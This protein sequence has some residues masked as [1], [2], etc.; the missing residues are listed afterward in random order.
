VTT[1]RAIL[2][3]VL[4]LAAGQALAAGLIPDPSISDTKAW[5]LPAGEEWAIADDDGHS[6]ASSLRYSSSKQANVPAVETSVQ[7]AANSEYVLTAWLKSDGTLR[8]AVYVLAPELEDQVVGQIIAGGEAGQWLAASAR[9]NSGAATNLRVRIVADPRQHKGEAIPAGTAAIDDLQ[10]WPAAE[11]PADLA[12]PGG[13]MRQAPGENLALDM[14]YTISPAPNYGYSTDEGDAY[15]L[16]DG[17]YSVGYFWVQKTTVGWSSAGLIDITVDLEER[18]PICG[19]SYNTAAGVAGVGWPAA[20]FLMVSDDGKTWFD[21]GEL[22]TLSTVNG[23]PP[24]EGYAVHRFWTGALKTSGRY[25]KLLVGPGT[26]YSFCDEVEIYEGPAALLQV[27]RGEPLGDTRQAAQAK[28]VATAV[29]QTILTEAKRVQ[30]D[31]ANT[32]LP[33]AERERLE[34]LI[35]QAAQGA[36]DLPA[37]DGNYRAIVPLNAAHA[38]VLQ[39]RAALNR[40]SGAA[41]FSIWQTDPY[42]P[43]Q[44]SEVPPPDADAASLDVAMLRN[45]VRPA[46]LN[47]T[48]MSDAPLKVHLA[49]QDV[50]DAPCPAWAD[51]RVVAW[52]GLRGGSITGSALPEADK[53]H[54]GWSVS[55]P[56]GTTTQLW[57]NVDSRR[58]K[59][60]Q[61]SGSLAVKPEGLQ[62]TKVPLRVEVV[63]VQMPDKL[64]LALGGWDYTSGAYSGVT[65]ENLAS[66]VSFLQEYHIDSPWATS[67]VMPFGTHAADGTMTTPPSTAAM[68]TWLARWPKSRYYCVFNAFSSPVP[69]TD[70]GRKR[71]EDWITFWVDYLKTKGVAPYQLA[72]LLAD[73]PHNAEQDALIVSYAKIIREVQPEVNVFNDPTWHDPR[74]ITPDLLETSGILCPNRPMWLNSPEIFSEVFLAQQK[75]GRQLAFYSCS[76]P[77]RDLDPYSYHRLQAWDCFRLGMV[78]EFFWAFSDSG[79]GSA[80]NEYGAGGVCYSPQFLGP[81]GCTTSKHME[82][83]REGL[84]DHEYLVLATTALAEAEAAGTKPDAVQR[85]KE[86]LATAP[87]RVL[88]AEGVSSISWKQDKD[89]TEAD[90]VRLEIINLLK[91]LK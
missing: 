51:M 57:L 81:D 47:L 4:A 65:N 87:G 25:V 20:V 23:A 72:L 89:R 10:I 91:E 54:D 59:A 22:T 71:V 40:A 63:D 27:D 33:G 38:G 1:H 37:L 60:G 15:Q 84:Y 18:R 39:V 12:V 6:G 11:A 31:L 73:E 74:Q 50:V 49:L 90:V 5:T 9:L 68:D 17:V 70:A 64:S 69:D 55:I 8:P 85:G 34:Q 28:V 41:P 82:A 32:T 61:F 13:I 14:P 79:N 53:L 46:T 7:C 36:D 78:G 80:W 52:T 75:A 56:S 86:L 83:V 35:A 66:V 48:N 44:I 88:N 19:V 30:A 3:L 77:V 67:G 21:A 43:L 62:I 24:A 42:Y 58:M 29:S 45:E 76:G 26:T 2:C 16:T